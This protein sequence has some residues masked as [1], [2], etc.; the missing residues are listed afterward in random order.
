VPSTGHYEVVLGRAGLPN[1]VLTVADAALV[2]PWPTG[3]TFAAT[4]LR[5]VVESIVPGRP[6]F[7]NLYEHGWW[8]GVEE[9]QV[10]LVFDV[11]S[12]EPGTLLEIRDVVVR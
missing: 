12:V 9:V 11:L 8:P 3:I 10:V 5:L 1:G 2:D 4:G 6:P 7:L